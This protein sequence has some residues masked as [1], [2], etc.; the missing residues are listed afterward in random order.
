MYDH[1]WV[2]SITK[3]PPEL[4]PDTLTVADIVKGNAAC[5]HCSTGTAEQRHGQGSNSLQL[6]PFCLQQLTMTYD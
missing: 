2:V 4:L 1:L 6:A 3:H 5:L